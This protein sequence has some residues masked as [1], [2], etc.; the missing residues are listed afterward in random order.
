[1]P[2]LFIMPLRHAVF[3]LLALM[4]ILWLPMPAAASQKI[5]VYAAASLT[6][7]ITEIS[8]VYEKEHKF[9]IRNSFA[10]SSALAKQIENGAPADIYISA[11]SNW[12]KYL[13]DQKLIAGASR[14]N[15]L[16]NRLVLIA[17]KVRAFKVQMDQAFNLAAAFDGKLCTGETESVP[18]GIYARQ[19]LTTM[20]W[21]DT[22]VSR[23]VGSQDVRAALAFV[24]RGECSA[25]IVYATDA[26][27]SDKVVMVA[28]FPDDSHGPI[29]YPAALLAGAQPT[30]QGFLDYL[31]SPTAQAIFRKYG[32]TPISK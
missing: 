5:T 10:S 19:A 32:F 15:L 29:V 28:A 18:A 21:W 25:G 11:D 22:L 6:N 24:E 30:A 20:H 4:A 3:H 31:H 12:M 8:S 17:P 9:K 2:R 14:M 26:R 16:S 13:Q 1:M 7:A 27:L 23:I